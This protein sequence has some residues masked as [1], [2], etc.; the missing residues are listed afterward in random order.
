MARG[1]MISKSLSTS[2]KFAALYEVAGPLAEFCQSLYPLLVSHA[3]D[4]GRLQGDAFTVKHQCF[5]ISPRTVPEFHDGL[6]FL[7]TVQLVTWYSVQ[8][9]K[10]LQIQKFD[11]HQMGLHKRTESLF[12]A[13]DENTSKDSVKLILPG[14]SGKVREVPGNSRSRARAELNRTEGKGT[15]GKGIKDPHPNNKLVQQF[16]PPSNGNGGGPSKRPIYQSDRFV[17]FEWQLDN[18]SRMLGPH[19]DGFDLH[20]WF[21]HLT[22]QSRD[23]GI[24]I[25][26]RCDDWLQAQTLAEAQRRGLQIATGAPVLGKQSTRIMNML[27]KIKAEAPGHDV[28]KLR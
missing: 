12:P 18:L 26:K 24:V 16:S 3:D 19:A 23:K 28:R 2:E 20:A 1:R 21:D 9:R 22:Q 27:A 13:P 25:P 7:D 17:V 15:E 14:I 4:F 10:Y 5:P 11:P 6:G 8:G